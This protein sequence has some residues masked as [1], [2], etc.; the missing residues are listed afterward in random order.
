MY[1]QSFDHII[2][3]KNR[4]FPETAAGNSSFWTLKKVKIWR[5]RLPHPVIRKL[6]TGLGL[7][8]RLSQKVKGPIVKF[9][10]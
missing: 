3:F 1:I 7:S 6:A 10:A 5:K 4:G 8:D 2:V 9:T